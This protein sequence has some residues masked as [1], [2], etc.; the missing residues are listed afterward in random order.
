[1][2]RRR[3]HT[4]SYSTKTCRRRTQQGARLQPG[5]ILRTPHRNLQVI[6]LTI[7]HHHRRRQNTPP[8][9]RTQVTLRNPHPQR[10]RHQLRKQNENRQG[11]TGDTR[12]KARNRTAPRFSNRRTQGNQPSRIPTRK[13]PTRT[14]RHNVTSSVNAS[15]RGTRIRTCIHSELHL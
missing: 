7:K 11:Q 1:M 4:R 3:T 10:S 15:R 13:G 8:G 12:A 5:T 6:Q 9:L 14:R 2:P